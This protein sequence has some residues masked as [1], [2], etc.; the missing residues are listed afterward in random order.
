MNFTLS[1]QTGI[2]T[3][4]CGLY[5]IRSVLNNAKLYYNGWYLPTQRSIDGSYDKEHVK[6]ACEKHSARITALNPNR[7]SA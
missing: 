3:S 1:K 7:A 2:A 4:Q 5:E 6:V